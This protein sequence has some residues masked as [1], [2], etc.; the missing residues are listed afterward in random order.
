LPDGAMPSARVS[1]PF[2]HKASAP[3][4]AALLLFAAGGTYAMESING[5]MTGAVDGA[6][7]SAQVSLHL[8]LQQVLVFS[9]SIF[10]VLA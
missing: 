3:L 4:D 7:P 6:M 8:H 1:A 10:I 9:L 2:A 5:G